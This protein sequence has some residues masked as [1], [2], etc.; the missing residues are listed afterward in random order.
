MIQEN[1]QNCKIF[2]VTDRTAST[3]ANLIKQNCESG[4]IIHS[5]GW[6]AYERINWN[7]LEIKHE[8]HIHQ[9]SKGKLR[10]FERCHLIEGLWG[11]LK[12]L[13]KHI[14]N[15]LPGNEDIFELFIQEAMWRRS[16]RKLTGN[17]WTE[18]VKTTYRFET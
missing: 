10:T 11:E 13:I 18:F 9:K 16:L 12:Y 2:I 17:E 7:T 3:L 4:S 14:Y 8:Q 1:N 5:D 6:A 15:T